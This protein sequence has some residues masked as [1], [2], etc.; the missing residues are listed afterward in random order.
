MNI[1]IDGRKRSEGHARFILRELSHRTKNLLAVVY[2]MARQTAKFGDNSSFAE[3]FGARLQGLARSHDLL[4]SSNWI[5]GPLDDHVR[6]QLGPFAPLDGHRIRISGPCLMLRPA[7][8]QALG[9]AFHELATNASKHGALAQANGRISIEW[10]IENGGGVNTFALTWQEQGLSVA[11]SPPLRRGFGY[12]VLSRVVPES[13]SG[14]AKYT[15]DEHGVHWGLR[16]P[17]DEVRSSA[18]STENSPTVGSG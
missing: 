2:A 4:V 3:D 10:G 14:E 16:A 17:L 5:G 18:D 12:T 1:D 6:S 11:P 9:L 7:A 8:V 13:L 15:L